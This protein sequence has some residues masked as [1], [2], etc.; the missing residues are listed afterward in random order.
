[1][2]LWWLILLL[3]IFLILSLSLTL[4]ILLLLLSSSSEWVLILF[5]FL[6]V[7]STA[8]R[9]ACY[10]MTFTLCFYESASAILFTLFAYNYSDGVHVVSN[11]F[12][13]LIAL[14]ALLTKLVLSV[15][16]LLIWCLLTRSGIGSFHLLV[17][18]CVWVVDTY[19]ICCFDK[20]TNVLFDYR[21]LIGLLC[22]NEN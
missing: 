3:D 10:E 8:L 14:L 9:I 19:G 7:L 15:M 12:T 22:K 6:L 2:Q 4:L 5:V 13:L 20:V 16:L 1:M 18:R 11:K 21:V 17:T